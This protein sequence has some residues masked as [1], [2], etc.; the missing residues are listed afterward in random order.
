MGNISTQVEPQ[1][2]NATE[3]TVTATYKDKYSGSGSQDMGD[4]SISRLKELNLSGQQKSNKIRTQSGGPDDLVKEDSVLGDTVQ[5]DKNQINVKRTQ[6]NTNDK[7]PR[8]N[9]T[10]TMPN[11]T[12]VDVRSATTKTEPNKD[13]HV[14]TYKHV[15]QCQHWTEPDLGIC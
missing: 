12:I 4:D 15:T 13:K 8:D 2:L 7:D 11:T 9:A 3:A 6:N 1:G 14:I 10:I 5:G